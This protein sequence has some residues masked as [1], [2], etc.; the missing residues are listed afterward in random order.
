MRI[1]WF[2]IPA[3][4]HTNP[5]FGLVRAMT[6]G[7]HEV[8]YF[9]FEM[10]RKQIEDAGAQFIG[11]D[12]YHFEMEDSADGARA[13]RD[14]AFSTRNTKRPPGRSPA[15][16]GGAGARKRPEP[17][18]RACCRRSG[19]P[20]DVFLQVL[21]ILLFAVKICIVRDSSI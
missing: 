11:C 17:F 12:G 2:C 7:G 20:W 14:L 4:G 3:C 18:W 10:F 19:A 5:T 6:E 13:G 15:A 16:F 21:T 8:Y 1:A 9:S